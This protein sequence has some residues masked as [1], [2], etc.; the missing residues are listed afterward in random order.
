MTGRRPSID[1]ELHRRLRNLLRTIGDDVRRTRLDIGASQAAVAAEAGIDRSHITRIEAGVAHPSLE[2][3]VAIATAMGADVSVRLYAGRG[4]R[5]TD[6]NAA[7]MIE[8]TVRQLAPAWRTHLEVH[9]TR[10]VRGFIDAVFERRDQ[11]LFVVTEFE[12][13]LPRLEQQIRWAAEKATAIGSSDLVGGDPAATISK[14][15]VLRST[16][17]TRSLAREF[18]STL[19]TAYPAS[20]KAAVQSLRTGAPW[21]GDAIAWIRIEGETVELLDGPPR[22]VSVGR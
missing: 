7:R 3:I 9:V 13:M 17:R 10:P 6:R 20:T 19:R 12:S 21:P 4:P 14:L 22:G 11:P 18:E 1:R 2:S 16:E 5:L 8:A 15:L